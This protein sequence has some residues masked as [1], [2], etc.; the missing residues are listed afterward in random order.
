MGELTLT[1]M[2]PHYDG[3][4]KLTP[5][6][7]RADYIA[8]TNGL[9]RLPSGI[10]DLFQRHIHAV[11]ILFDGGGFGGRLDVYAMLRNVVTQDPLSLKLADH[12]ARLI[13]TVNVHSFIAAVLGT[14]V[15]PIW[16][17]RRDLDQ[18]PRADRFG[19]PGEF[20]RAHGGQP[21]CELLHV[22]Q[23]SKGAKELDGA[24]LSDPTQFQ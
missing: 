14:H 12:H 1:R 10:V 9:G 22:G 3:D 18:I 24:R 2:S 19:A 20:V 17:G 21:A 7:I 11:G 5:T 8:C 4:Q 15:G 16:S 23:H 13:N 6:P